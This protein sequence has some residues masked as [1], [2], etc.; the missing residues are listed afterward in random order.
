[1]ATT[2]MKIFNMHGFDDR[3]SP[4]WQMVPVG[5][6]RYIVLTEGDGLT[7]TSNTPRVVT[8]QEI[9][10]RDIPALG[11]RSTFLIPVRCFRLHG[12]AKGAASIVASDGSRVVERLLI[13]T[14]Q[15]KTLR[16]TF[17]FVRD[18]E[19]PKTSH[20]PAEAAQWVRELN[21]IYQQCNVG[22]VC[23]AARWITV[24]RNL[25]WVIS[26]SPDPKEN[27]EWNAVT[28][29]RDPGANVNVFCFN[30]VRFGHPL[31]DNA[32]AIGGGA[33]TDLM[34]D[35]ENPYYVATM[36][37]EIGHTQGLVHP[38]RD[39]YDPYLLMA[40]GSGVHM[41]RDDVNK[42]NP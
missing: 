31:E 13:D 20:V 4:T 6:D 38:T 39:R 12:V 1:M 36:A 10:A 5:G 26:W 40:T 18:T 16:V 35:D 29:R 21:W 32:W 41:T 24:D 3:R 25:G 42:M 33:G 15:T 7:V 34:L 8:L 30:D 28:A 27:E 2:F 23:R 37:H 19:G 14:K 17:N 22:I 11:P 9:K